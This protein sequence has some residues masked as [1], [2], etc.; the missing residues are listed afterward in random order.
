MFALLAGLSA[1]FLMAWL[2]N[3]G[4][5]ETADPALTP[6]PISGESDD[7]LESDLD[8]SN[9]DLAA[10]SARRAE[11]ASELRRKREPIDVS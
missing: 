4:A 6:I 2:F 9:A 3:R 10:E 1:L 7:T 8:A 5:D 11:L